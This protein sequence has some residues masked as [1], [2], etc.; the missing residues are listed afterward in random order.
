M[1]IV[2]I[3]F[4]FILTRILKDMRAYFKFIN[5]KLMPYLEAP[6]DHFSERYED[7]FHCFLPWTYRRKLTSLFFIPLAA[8]TFVFFYISMVTAEPVPC[9]ITVLC[10]YNSINNTITNIMLGKFDRLSQ[11]DISMYQ[12][13]FGIEIDQ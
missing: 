12:A 2:D 7:F 3:F 13:H 4:M 5:I 11:S 10:G 1:A 9:F 8:T 6:V